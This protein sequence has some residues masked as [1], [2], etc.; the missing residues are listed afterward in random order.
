LKPDKVWTL[1]CDVYSDIFNL[2]DEKPLITFLNPS[3]LMK[4]LEFVEFDEL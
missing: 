1:A 4:K 3:D 2:L